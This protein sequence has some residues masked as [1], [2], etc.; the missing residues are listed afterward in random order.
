MAK[1]NDGSNAA[2]FLAGLTVGIASAVLFAPRSGKETRDSIAEA[3]NRGRDF[4]DRKRREVADF[5]REVFDQGRELASDAK[6]AVD[7]G[8]K[9]LADL[10]TKV[11]DDSPTA[12]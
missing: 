1:R 7:K 8:K 6:E 5:G 9:I 12:N 2:W 3:T 4:A 11:Q 10:N